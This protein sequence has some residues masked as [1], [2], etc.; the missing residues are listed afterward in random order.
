METVTTWADGF[1][2]WHARVTVPGADSAYLREH[3]SRIRAKAR[4]AI[5]REITVRDTVG[6]RWRCAVEAVPTPD[7]AQYVTYRER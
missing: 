2:R 4:R 5:R 7:T 6:P 3:A 1:G